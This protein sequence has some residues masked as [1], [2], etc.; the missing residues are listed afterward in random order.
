[1][2][3]SAAS[4]ADGH[5]EAPRSLVVRAAWAA[6]AL[7]VI[8]V[9]GEVAARLD[10]ALFHSVPL[11]A[12]PRREDLIM[13]DWFGRRGRPH[14]QFGKWKLNSLG[15]RG[16]EL[17]H[18]EPGCIRVVVLGASE[19][20]GYAESPEH[21]YPSVLQQKLA[22][23]GCVEVV[24]AALIGMQLGSM[25]S[26]WTNWVA[27]IQPDVVVVY[28][29]P[30]FYLASSTPKPRGTDRA[31][32]PS[33]SAAAE[34][35][36]DSGTARFES[37]FIKRLRS[38]VTGALPR[39]IPMYLNQRRV[40]AELAA[41]ALPLISAP[42]AADLDKFRQAL[43]QL[44]DTI[45]SSGARVVLL[46]HAQRA[47]LPIEAR[48]L[49]D[50]WEARIYWPRAELPVLA[51]F[52]EAG[53]DVIREVARHEEVQLIDVAPLLDGCWDCFADLNHFADKGAALMAEAIAGDLPLQPRRG[54][55]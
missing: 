5:A 44:L 16:P 3:A 30:L 20:F 49:P 32:T 36:A 31:V 45:K 39:W 2:R 35:P 22:G 25:R 1:L 6:A 9:C 54:G 17:R 18:K 13:Q 10:D 15:F 29:S 11:L 46:T 48:M 50:L 21:E 41:Q 8:G 53:N 12:N 34:S 42:P 24:N 47:T 4:S 7:L 19:S 40:A 43:T 37:R 52:N 26:Y 14:A 27:K 55:D 33:A 38:V 51:Q 28:P 23:E